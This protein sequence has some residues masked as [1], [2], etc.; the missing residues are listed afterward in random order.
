MP[1]ASRAKSSIYSILLRRAVIRLPACFCQM[2]HP[3][4]PA[5]APPRLNKPVSDST[6]P[7]DVSTR[8]RPR[9]AHNSLR[10]KGRLQDASQYARANALQK[11]S[12]EGCCATQQSNKTFSCRSPASLDMH[13]YDKR[14][15][16][17]VYSSGINMFRDGRKATMLIQAAWRRHHGP[18][19]IVPS[20]A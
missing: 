19:F 16:H 9:P 8:V 17:I 10:N 18:C 5:N 15:G 20:G 1:D 2:E 14:T 13:T 12:A 11:I 6:T 3:F 7:P 4:L